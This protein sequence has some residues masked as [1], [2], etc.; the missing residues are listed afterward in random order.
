MALSSHAIIWV[1]FMSLEMHEFR[2]SN[3]N[4]KILVILIRIPIVQ[5]CLNHT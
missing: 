3:R 4:T 2:D 1:Y 5:K